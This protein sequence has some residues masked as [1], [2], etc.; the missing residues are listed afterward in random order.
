MTEDR[1]RCA[2]IKRNGERRQKQGV[3]PVGPVQRVCGWHFRLVLY[4]GWDMVGDREASP[5]D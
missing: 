2:A 4:E 3:H 5:H 1:Y